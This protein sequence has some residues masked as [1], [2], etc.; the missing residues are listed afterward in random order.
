ME[1]MGTL[2]HWVW[3]T[4]G[5]LLA[6]GEMLATQFVLIWFGAAAI[7]VGVLAWIFPGFGL[8]GQLVAFGL[9]SA[10][11]VMPA[12][13]LRR[14]WRNS[15][16]GSHINERVAQQVGR[17]S[18]LKEPIIGG[19]GRVFIGDTLWR[20]EGPDLPAGAAVRVVSFDDTTLI[21]EAAD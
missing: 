7:A 9:L 16:R 12:R 6:A 20:V 17:V 3:L 15:A 14:R 8:A 19:Q 18:I 13:L 21:V 5:L 4:V 2:P 1:V 11:L 10:V